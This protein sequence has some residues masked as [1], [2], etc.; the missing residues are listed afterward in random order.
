MYEDG[1]FQ[2]RWYIH[3]CYREGVPIKVSKLR[4]FLQSRDEGD[5]SCA[6]V[7][8]VLRGLG[9]RFKK[10]DTRPQLFERKDIV[11]QRRYFCRDIKI[12]RFKGIYLLQKVEN[13]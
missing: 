6:T 13:Q 7:H 8:R 2:I 12:Y 11:M 9:Y 3:N 5:Y 4:E 1:Y 10:N